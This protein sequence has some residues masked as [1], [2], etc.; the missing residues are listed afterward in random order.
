MKAKVVG[1]KQYKYGPTLQQS[2]QK[3]INEILISKSS[4]AI[5]SKKYLQGLLLHKA[6]NRTNSTGGIQEFS[7]GHFVLHSPFCLYC[8]FNMDRCILFKLLKEQKKSQHRLIYLC[9]H[10]ILSFCQIAIMRN[11]QNTIVRWFGGTS[12]AHA[13]DQ[14]MYL[15]HNSSSLNIALKLTCL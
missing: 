14:H 6:E 11:W 3:A 2:K 15:E 12:R 8:H 5:N 9:L 1:T 13:L 4:V 10:Y 7:G